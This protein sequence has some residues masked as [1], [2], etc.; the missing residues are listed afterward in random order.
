MGVMMRTLTNNKGDIGLNNLLRHHVSSLCP[1]PGNKRTNVQRCF[2]PLATHP[3][4][5]S[6]IKKHTESPAPIEQKMVGEMGMWYLRQI[7]GEGGQ[8]AR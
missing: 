5:F 7:E 3:S 6:C 8:Q 2:R 4:L 1:L